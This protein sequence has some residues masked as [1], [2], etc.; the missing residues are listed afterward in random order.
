MGIKSVDNLLLGIENS[1]T[2]PLWRLLTGLNIR[3]VG[4]SNARVLASHYHD[5]K[6]LQL[7]SAETL[8]SI[9]EIGPV[10][11]ESVH[12]FLN[13]SYGRNIL[14]HLTAAGVKPESSLAIENEPEQAAGPISGKTLVVTGTLVRMTRM[15][16]QDLIRQHGGKA[17][18]S[19]SKNTDFLVIGDNAGSKL[20]RAEEL[21]VKIL[22]ESDFHELLAS[23]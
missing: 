15:E 2:R 23:S 21:G 11:A 17:S 1:K 6:Q 10:I 16:M 12:E 9:N 18:G 5:L 19:V 4:T 7:Q 14:E 13:S 22:S 20:A 3:H 8:A